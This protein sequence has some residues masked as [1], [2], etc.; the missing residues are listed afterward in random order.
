MEINYSVHD[1][2]QRAKAPHQAQ[3]FAELAKI[4]GRDHGGLIEAYRCDMRPRWCC[5]LWA[6]SA[7]P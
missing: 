2:M 5:W 1:A 4:T 3:V 7:A 6:R